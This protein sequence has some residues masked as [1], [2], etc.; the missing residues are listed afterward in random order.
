MLRSIL[1]KYKFDEHNIQVTPIGSGLINTTWKIEDGKSSFVLQKINDHVFKQPNFIDENISLVANFL[2]QADPEYLFIS[3]LYSIEGET[4]IYQEG[5]GYFR[6]FSYVSDS[7]TITTV[8]TANQAYEAAFQFGRFTALC[9]G[10]D[11]RQLKTTIPD[12]HNLS[13]RYQQFQ[14]AIIT[15]N[16]KR[17]GHAKDII[18]E[19]EQYKWILVQYEK[20]KTDTQ[21]KLRVTHHDTKISNVLFN[22]NEKAICVIDLDTIMPGYFISDVGDMIRT[23]VCQVSEEEKDF[24]KIEIRK[25]F[26]EAIIAGYNA[27]MKSELTVAEQSSFFYAGCFMIYMQAI[28]FLTDYLQEDIYYGAKYEDHNFIRA[29]NQLILLNKLNEFQYNSS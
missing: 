9:K 21:F 23:Y 2:K 18:D 3:P 8:Q 1:D 19:L 28:R 15:G 16:S 11:C 12:F 24:S 13:L 20:I 29:S 6:L 5:E 27:A 25:E 7:K 26:Y 4:L 10:I 22:K 14:K 17:I